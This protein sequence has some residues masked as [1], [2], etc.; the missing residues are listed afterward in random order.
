MGQ[1]HPV[2][3]PLWCHCSLSVGWEWQ[4]APAEGTPGGKGGWDGGETQLPPCGASVPQFPHPGS[5]GVHHPILSSP[6][7][8]PAAGEPLHPPAWA[9]GWWHH[10][11]GRRRTGIGGTSQHPPCPHLPACIPPAYMPLPA[12]PCLRPPACIP[13]PALPCL[14]LST[15]IP[16]PAPP[17]LHSPCLH[18][19]PARPCLHHPA[20]SPLPT[21]IPVPTYILLPSY[22]PL[23][24]SPCPHPARLPAGGGE[25]AG[26]A[27]RAAAAGGSGEAIPPR[28]PTGP[29]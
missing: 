6:G 13:L 1:P 17:C 2:P 10:A 11:A 7:D 23:P 4:P 15:C 9:P 3:G 16:L 8:Q 18:P 20:C 27:A 19:L 28:F 24:M 29:G 12:L 22:N 25:P 14:H 5:P 26:Y 21:Y